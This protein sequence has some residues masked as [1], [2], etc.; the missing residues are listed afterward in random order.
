MTNSAHSKPNISWAAENTIEHLSKHLGVSFDPEMLRLALTHRSY[1]FEHD[2][3]PTN[4]R[5]EFLGDAVLGVLVTDYLYKTFSDEAENELAKKRASIVSTFALAYVARGIDLGSYIFLGAGEIRTHGGNKDSILADTFE[6]L[7]GATYLHAGFDG[8]WTIVK[9]HVIPLLDNEHIMGAGKDWKTQVQIAVDK[10]GLG[11]IEYRIE[12]TGPDHDRT[13]R[14]TLVVGGKTYA[15][16]QAK[17]KKD[18]E[19]LAAWHSL[20]DIEQP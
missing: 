20:S 18:A 7:I 11:P 6:A 10:K 4:E 12:G 9:Q 16:A 5:L 8:A 3:L 15:T 13:F 2:G 17:T 1:A 19:R 14:A